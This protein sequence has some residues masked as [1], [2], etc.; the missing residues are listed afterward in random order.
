MEYI[1]EHYRQYPQQLNLLPSLHGIALME[2]L[3]MHN[4][5]PEQI[6]IDYDA[7][8]RIL[9]PEHV[10]KHHSMEEVMEEMAKRH[11]IEK[12]REWLERRK[13]APPDPEQAAPSKN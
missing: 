11:G 10:L 6:G 13:P 9:K 5:T 2:T 7:L 12:M 4:L 1:L 3:L 8:G